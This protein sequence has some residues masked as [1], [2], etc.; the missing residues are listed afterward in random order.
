[1][2]KTYSCPR[3]EIEKYFLFTTVHNNTATSCTTATWRPAHFFGMEVCHR[4]CVRGHECPSV[5]HIC[6]TFSLELAEVLNVYVVGSHMWETCTSSSD[7]DIVIVVQQHTVASTP[8]NA[9]KGSLEAFI[10]SEQQYL[11]QVGAHSMQILLTLW[12]P[13]CC[14]LKQTVDPR[15]NFKFSEATLI[16]SMAA[17]RDRDLRVAEKHFRKRNTVQAKRVLVHCSRYLDVAVQLKVHRGCINFT[18]ANRFREDIL[19]NYNESWDEFIAS[20]GCIVKDLW[21]KLAIND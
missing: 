12:L 14:I 10:L 3:S 20:V 19:S 5:S 2:A 16:S 13:D 11:E 1:M 9:H 21:S 7:W 15:T 18:S 8:K 17:S 6:K 4:Y